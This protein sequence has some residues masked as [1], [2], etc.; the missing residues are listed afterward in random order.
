[1]CMSHWR[2]FFSVAV[3][4][5]L[6][7]RW[8]YRSKT[9]LTP[10]CDLLEPFFH[11]VLRAVNIGNGSWW[12]FQVVLRFSTSLWAVACCDNRRP[13]QQEKQLWIHGGFHWFADFSFCILWKAHVIVISNPWSLLVSSSFLL[14][15]AT[16][17]YQHGP[18]WSVRPSKQMIHLWITRYFVC[19]VL[20]VL[21]GIWCLQ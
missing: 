1:M 12:H 9:G 3:T 15:L 19:F 10:W 20:T 21:L 7:C 11:V 18:R 2:K 13:G 8:M 16:L 4:F 5:G 6:S 14:S 17:M